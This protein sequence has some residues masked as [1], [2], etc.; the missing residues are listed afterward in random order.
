MRL[1]RW[2]RRHTLA[3]FGLVAYGWTWTWDAIFFVFDLWDVIPVTLPRVW[4][5]AIAAVVVIWA[6]K[7]PLRTW[8]RQRLTWRVP[9]RYL[10]VAVL[11]PI[12]I[13]N[14]QPFIEAV[15]GGTVAYDP[16]AP[17]YGMAAFVVANMVLFG[18]TEE[19]G[20]RG[21]AQPR[22][23]QRLSVFTTGLVIG[24]AWWIWHFPLFF[25]GNPNYT[26]QVLPLLT[27]TLFILGISVVLGAFVNIAEGTL[28]PVILMHA[29]VNAGA[30]FAVEGGFLEGSALVPLLVGSGLWWVLAGILLGVYGRSMTPETN[31]GSVA[32]PTD[33]RLA[34]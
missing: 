31:T 14:V 33:E 24:V 7:I 29:S 1:K 19:L 11:I 25:T 32:P 10:L 6:S 9:P 20:W 13:T 22:L 26:F 30:L 5:P 27:Y 12:G 17:I 28:L 4:G 15:G 3:A 2:M 18:G 21:I 23:Q 8:A 34:S 16:P